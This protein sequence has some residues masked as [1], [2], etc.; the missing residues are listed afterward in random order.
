MLTLYDA[1]GHPV[2]KGIRRG[3]SYQVND[4]GRHPVTLQ[5]GQSAYFGFGWVNKTSN[6]HLLAQ[7]QR[8]ATPSGTE[9]G[10]ARERLVIEEVA[11]LLGARP[12]ESERTHGRS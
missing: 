4:P 3:N 1:S 7:V 11:S 5:P 8:S 12:A 6:A 2:S 9:P 10:K